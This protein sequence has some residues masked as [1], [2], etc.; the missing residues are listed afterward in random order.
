MRSRAKR[1]ADCPP[2]PCLSRRFN[3]RIWRCTL[4]V[5]AF[6]EDQQKTY[7]K[8][9]CCFPEEYHT[10]IHFH[11]LRWN[12]ICH[13][14]QVIHQ[15]PRCGIYCRKDREK[16]LWA[17]TCFTMWKSYRG[18]KRDIRLREHTVQNQCWPAAPYPRQSLLYHNTL[19][20]HSMVRVSTAWDVVACLMLNHTG[21]NLINAA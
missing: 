8:L 10:E 7:A 1:N 3:T 6:W 11:P 18:K 13:H 20:I 12:Q 2:R 4:V 19:P 21:G 14:L 5:R 16:C 9:P 17:W 15:V